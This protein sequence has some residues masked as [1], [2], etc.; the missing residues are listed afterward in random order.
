MAFQLTITTTY[1]PPKEVNVLSAKVELANDTLQLT[2]ITKMEESED[3]SV[4]DAIQV[5]QD[6]W[7]TLFSSVER[8]DT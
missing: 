1:S 6:S 7:T 8:C 4:L 3:F 5:L 2:T